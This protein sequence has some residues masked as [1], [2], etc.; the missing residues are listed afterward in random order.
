MSQTQKMIVLFVPL[1]F[2]TFFFL[3]V[4]V[5]QY[6]PLYP[7]EEVVTAYNEK[8]AN[9]TIPILS[10]DPIL[11]DKKAKKTLV[12]FGDYG[13]APCAS[14]HNTLSI[15][16][17]K[18]PKQ[19]NVIWKG[20]TNNPDPFPKTDAHRLAYCA[21]QQGKFIPFTQTAYALRGSF[22]SASLATLTKDIGLR[23]GRFNTCLESDLPDNY[24]YQTAAVG[25]LLQIQQLPAIFYNDK[26]IQQPETI[27]EWEVILGLN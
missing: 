27:E 23:K 13:C 14:L 15:L 16:L 5:M 25:R 22:S 24:M 20:L 1:I 11:G 17:E 3:F 12:V 21:N 7:S 9:F 18:H 4:R 6:T 26:Q 8:L 2:I 10:E 19:F